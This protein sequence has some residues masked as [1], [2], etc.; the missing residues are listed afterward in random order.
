MAKNRRA[1]GRN[2]AI[3][4]NIKQGVGK[5]IGNKQMEAAGAT[6][7]MQGQAIEATAKASERIAGAAQELS[8][9]IKH[10]AGNQINNP[11][12]A[13]EGQAEIVKGKHR[14]DANK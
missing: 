5:L 9:T 2:Q 14:Q 12:L 8:G 4:G 11:E 3:A 10:M 13:I 6:E 1:Q 7:V